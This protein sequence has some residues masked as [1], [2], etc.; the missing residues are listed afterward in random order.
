MINLRGDSYSRMCCSRGE[1][2]MSSGLQIK[3]VGGI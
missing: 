1:E 3:A 2:S